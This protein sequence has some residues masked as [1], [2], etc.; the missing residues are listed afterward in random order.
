MEDQEVNRYDSWFL[1]RV[2]VWDERNSMDWHV[3]AQLCVQYMLHNQ[4]FNFD[5]NH[6]II[7]LSHL[8]GI[9]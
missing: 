7:Q 5:L 6:N 3:R 1:D 9:C 8:T 4:F 2:C